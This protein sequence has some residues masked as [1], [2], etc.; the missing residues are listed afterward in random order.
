MYVCVGWWWM[1]GSVCVCMCACVYVYVC[2]CVVNPAVN[3][4][5]KIVFLWKYT[6]FCCLHGTWEKWASP[7]ESQDF[8]TTVAS[9]FLEK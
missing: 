7:K 6:G 1:G 9:L 4:M 3:C 2:V 5:S 8:Q